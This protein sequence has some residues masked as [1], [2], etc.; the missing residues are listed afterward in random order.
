MERNHPGWILAGWALD[1]AAE[2]LTVEGQRAP[3]VD[4]LEAGA[5]FVHEEIRAEELP[6][7]FAPVGEP[8]PY[9]APSKRP[10]PEPAT[11]PA[12]APVRSVCM[13]CGEPALREWS[14]CPRCGGTSFLESTEDIHE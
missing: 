14:F 10:S 1:A 8:W 12:A 11:E 2:F 5:D 3:V 6:G 9:F 13:K 4:L 7:A